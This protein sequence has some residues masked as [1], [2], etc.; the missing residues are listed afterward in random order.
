MEV[1]WSG[2]QSRGG[3]GRAHIHGA[4]D[5]SASQ[6]VSLYISEDMYTISLLFRDKRDKFGCIF[7]IFLRSF[8]E[9]FNVFKRLFQFA[10]KCV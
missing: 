8:E 2:G 5:V 1:R 4:Q 10:S 9:V 6:S 7:Y 3:G